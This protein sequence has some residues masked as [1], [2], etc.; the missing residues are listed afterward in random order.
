MSRY[1]IH[2]RATGT[3]DSRTGPKDPSATS[4]LKDPNMHMAQPG[5]DYYIPTQAGMEAQIDPP[6]SAPPGSKY[7][8]CGRSGLLKFRRQESP[9]VQLQFGLYF[10]LQGLSI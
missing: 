5:I 3:A 4:A 7:P 2:K 9:S 6:E 1:I 10:K 8:Y